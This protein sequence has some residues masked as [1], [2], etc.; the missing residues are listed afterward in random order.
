MQ[1]H[2]VKASIVADCLPKAQVESGCVASIY[3][4]RKPPASASVSGRS[5]LAAD[6]DGIW[7]GMALPPLLVARLE[8]LKHKSLKRKSLKQKFEAQKF[9]K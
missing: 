3:Q 5:R 4:R 9:L 2:A 7:V 6:V 8:S 1:A